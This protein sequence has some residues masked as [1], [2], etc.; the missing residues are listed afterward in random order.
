M[1]GLPLVHKFND[2]IISFQLVNICRNFV[3][4]IIQVER[5][6]LSHDS[7]ERSNILEMLSNRSSFIASNSLPLIEYSSPLLQSNFDRLTIVD[8]PF[9][10]WRAFTIPRLNETQFDAFL[11]SQIGNDAYK[12]IKPF[13]ILQTTKFYIWKTDFAFYFCIKIL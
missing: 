8:E 11:L 13:E 10:K 5:L 1:R 2:F 6:L 7:N 3:N 9:S 4:W 12:Q